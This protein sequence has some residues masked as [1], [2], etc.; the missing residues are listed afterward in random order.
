MRRYEAKLLVPSKAK[1]IQREIMVRGVSRLIPIYLVNE[2]P[3]SGGTWLKFMLADALGVPAWTKGR[4]TWG[5]CVMQ[6]HWLRPHGRCRTVVL[7]RDA[8][9]VMVSYYFHCFFL[10]EFQNAALV[11]VMR[12]RFPFDD[13]EDVR[14]NLLSFMQGI[15]NDPVAPGFRWIDFVEVWGRRDDIV[16]T[17]YEDL[18]RDAT[19]EL[20]RL[21]EQLTGRA[22]P[23]D[24]AQ[25][26]VERFTM[27]NMRKQNAELNPGIVGRQIAEMSF[28]RKG[29]VGGWSD[30]FTD[31]A[32][33]W[34][35]QIHR[36]ALELLGY[37]P[38]RP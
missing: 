13:Y 29:S 16:T 25:R 14:S 22:L 31:E 4:T 15:Q 27:D 2:F 21:V 37:K 34:F 6:G 20:E 12:A 32:L 33:C 36:G 28:I 9:D 24:E 38:G 7:F 19:S 30:V 10:N 1:M 17:R 11:R 35:D 18:R 8:R 3:K 5:P 23:K 26:I